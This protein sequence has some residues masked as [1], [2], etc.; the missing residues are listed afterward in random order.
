M[1][2]VAA[3]PVAPGRAAAWTSAQVGPTWTAYPAERATKTRV[4]LSAAGSGSKRSGTDGRA[5][6]EGA[7]CG[8]DARAAA[9]A[10]AGRGDSGAA[11]TRPDD[12]V[13]SAPKA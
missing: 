1:G 2:S 5:M 6:V 10:A 7:G 13:A 9:D 3:V 4:P 11:A 12:S 8:S